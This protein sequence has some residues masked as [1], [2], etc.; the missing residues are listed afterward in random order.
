MEPKMNST[1]KSLAISNIFFRHC[2][3]TRINVDVAGDNLH[4]A[5][6]KPADQKSALVIAAYVIAA[7][8]SVFL[9][10][11][12][13][14]LARWQVTQCRRRCRGNTDRNDVA[15]LL[16]NEPDER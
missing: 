2:M 1:C 7:V 3:M 4:C 13:V 5:Y 9:V 15:N 14:L 16:N 10:P 11:L 6:A 8:C 12:L